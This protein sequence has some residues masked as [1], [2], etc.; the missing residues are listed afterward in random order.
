[1]GKLQEKILFIQQKW[2][3]RSFHQRQ[4]KI[5]SLEQAKT[6]EK[7]ITGI[8][9]S[10]GINNKISSV[11]FEELKDG[12]AYYD[13]IENSIRVNIKSF[14]NYSDREKLATFLEEYGHSISSKY[15]SQIVDKLSDWLGRYV[16]IIDGKPLDIVW[17]EAHDLA[18]ISL[19]EKYNPEMYNII[20][21]ETILDI[22]KNSN[23]VKLIS[24]EGRL[25]SR[26]LEKLYA[27]LS[28]DSYELP[29]LSQWIVLEGDK[30]KT[31]LKRFENSENLKNS[32]LKDK[33]IKEI[34]KAREL[35]D[36]YR[37]VMQIV[38]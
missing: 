13:E 1:V 33:T 6:S 11:I 37:E 9:K 4:D 15:D 21:Q 18:V 19:Y 27:F 5:I 22:E 32:V 25:S 26:E 7:A 35:A 10:T 12:A 23:V 16:N 34:E 36:N 38:K 17:N 3:R 28:E 24:K 30:A 14:E 29:M 2:K 31:I 20:K 8:A